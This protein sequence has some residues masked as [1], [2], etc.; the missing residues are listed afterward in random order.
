MNTDEKKERERI[1]KGMKKNAGSFKKRYGDRAKEVMYAT[2]TK[3]AQE[4]TMNEETLNE[5]SKWKLKAY[6]RKADKS[7][8]KAKF[9]SLIYSH[10]D[11]HDKEKLKSAH[12][13]FQKRAKGDNRA[14]WRLQGKRFM[15]TNSGEPKFS[16]YTHKKKMSEETLNEL[17]KKTLKSYMK[18]AE[19]SVDKMHNARD[20]IIDKIDR[21]DDRKKIKDLDKQDTKLHNKIYDREHRLGGAVDRVNGIFVHR[22]GGKKKGRWVNSKYTAEETLNELSKKTLMSYMQKSENEYYKTLDK[23]KK[24]KRLQGI[25]KAGLSHRK[26]LKEDFTHD[27]YHKAAESHPKY[28]HT[29]VSKLGTVIHHFKD[30]KTSFTSHIGGNIRVANVM[31]KGKTVTHRSLSSFKKHLNEDTLNELSDA[32]LADYKKKAEKSAE[33]LGNKAYKAHR[34]FRRKTGGNIFH[35]L[36]RAYRNEPAQGPGSEARKLRA[37]KEKRERYAR[38]ASSWNSEGSKEG[39]K[40]RADKRDRRNIKK[41][42]GVINKLAKESVQ[43]IMES[44]NSN[45]INKETQ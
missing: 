20:K 23:K 8:E 31:H 41:N 21:T 7:A 33:K 2:A 5:L 13:T 19:R 27:E 30:G 26:K 10:P 37:K 3:L 1:V 4:E 43:K 25:V 44:I 38:A 40:E 36:Y 18:K 11:H 14:R 22:K 35:D 15:H 28:S 29:K 45:N 6:L 42:I 39:R 16:D 34:K 32:K 12:K 9:D 17:S 24:N